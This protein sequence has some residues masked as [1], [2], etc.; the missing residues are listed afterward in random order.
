VDTCVR[1][2]TKASFFAPIP[3]RAGGCRPKKLLLVIGTMLHVQS[4][5]PMASS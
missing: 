3:I 1:D 4:H 5:L 2:G